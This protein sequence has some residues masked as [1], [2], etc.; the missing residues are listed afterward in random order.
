MEVDIME[1]LA[2]WGPHITSHALHWDGYG[3][4]HKHTGSGHVVLNESADGFHTYGVNWQPGKITFYVDGKETY[5][6]SDPRVGSVEAYILLSLQMGGWKDS[7]GDNQ[8]VD[9]AKLPGEM[10]I[11]YVRVWSGS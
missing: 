3:Q 8:Q 4:D 9:D 10:V 6:W 2:Q 11:D 5:S 7:Y 1:S